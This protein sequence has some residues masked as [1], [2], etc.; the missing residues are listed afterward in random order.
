MTAIMRDD[1]EVRR[2]LGAVVAPTLLIWGMLD[3]VLPPETA[4]TLASRLTSTD[5][6]L[7]RLDDV[8]HYPPLEAPV[9]VA[10]ATVGFLAS[11]QSSADRSN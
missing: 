4:D 9:E 8:N 1:S 5:P 3:P 11:L 2:L 10:Q 7:V 6:G